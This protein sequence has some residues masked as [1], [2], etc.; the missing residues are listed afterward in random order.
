[1]AAKDKH[2]AFRLSALVRCAVLYENMG[3]YDKAV[4]AYRDLIQNADDDDLVI[5]AKE[6]VS[7][8]EAFGK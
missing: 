2:D 5:A 7:E 4:S 3:K 1:M 8:L 6:R